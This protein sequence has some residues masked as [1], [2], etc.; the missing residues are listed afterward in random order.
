M[1]RTVLR[2]LLW[3]SASLWLCDGVEFEPF[4]RSEEYKCGVFLQSSVNDQA[5]TLFYA[6]NNEL[7]HALSSPFPH[8]SE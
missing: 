6:L 3:L 8:E 1:W 2:S 5:M 7:I 4:Q